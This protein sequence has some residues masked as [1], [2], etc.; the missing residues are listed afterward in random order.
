MIRKLDLSNEKTANDVYK[1]Q[2]ASYSIEAELIGFSDIPPLK[3]TAES[4]KHCNEIFYG[5]YID[6]T[7]AGIISYKFIENIIDICRVAVHPSFFRMG[8]AGKL[9]DFAEDLETSAAGAT[10]STGKDNLPA[11]N[12]YLKKGFKRIRDIKVPEGIYI[13]DFEKSF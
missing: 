3:D 7:L 1:L 5:Y 4:L 13:T 10:V 8:I 11:V 6:D 9:I 12:L 2:T